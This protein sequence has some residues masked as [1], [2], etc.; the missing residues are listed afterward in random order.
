MRRIFATIVAL[1][2]LVGMLPVQAGSIIVDTASGSLGGLTFTNEGISGNTAT[3]L[4]G[5]TPNTQSFLNNVNGVTVALDPVAVEGPITLLVTFTATPGV[6]DLALSPST[7]NAVFG[8]T[9]G[10][11]G[12]LAFNQ[13][14]GIAPLALP[15]FFN[16]SGLI[17]SVVANTE[18]TYD[19]SHMVG[20]SMNFT[21]TGTTF[22]GANSFFGL[23][24]T[25][26]A[27]VTASGSFSMSAVPEPASVMQMGLGI[28]VV[29]FLLALRRRKLLIA[30]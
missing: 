3:I 18:P 26:G 12:I 22:T 16:M 15:D 28:G 27:K 21:V 5:S 6:Y 29:V 1:S 30:S 14:K 8:T 11:Q 7:Y 23:F 4:I 2:C 10:A 24:A 17:T 19:F 25:P 9:V 20:G 13:E